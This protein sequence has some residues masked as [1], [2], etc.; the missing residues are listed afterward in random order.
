MKSDYFFLF[1]TY[2]YCVAQVGLKLLGS[3]GLKHSYSLS[4][5]SSSDHRY[6]PLGL[7]DQIFKNNETKGKD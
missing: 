7:A 6:A 2:S 3:L 5:L 1:E 4:F